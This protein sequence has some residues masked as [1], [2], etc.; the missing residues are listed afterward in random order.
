MRWCADRECCRDRRSTPAPA[1]GRCVAGAAR[2]GIRLHRQA[3]E[4]LG[5]GRA[6]GR[7]GRG[8]GEELD[9]DGGEVRREVGEEIKVRGS[10]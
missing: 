4:G 1:T 9:S 7:R 3:D 8:P 5:A 6:G 2:Q 10:P